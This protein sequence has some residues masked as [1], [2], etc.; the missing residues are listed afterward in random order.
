MK[1]LEGTQTKINLLKG[2]AGESEARNRYTFFAGVAKR[3][4]YEQISA[5]FL[6]T[7][8]NE[9]AH[10]KVFFRYLN[11]ESAEITS[12]VVTG[13]LKTTHECLLE[14]AAGEYNEWHNLYNTWADT[15][16]QEGFPD[17]ADSLRLIATVEMHHENR[18]RKLAGN[19]VDGTV[20]EKPLVIK[21]ICRNCGYIHEGEDAPDVCP[22]CKH[23]QAFFEVL[24]DN[25]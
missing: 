12:E 20:F 14:A 1:S 25:F 19:I 17:I 4:G 9:R 22:V 15:A 24:A 18:Y 5:I 7:A 8:D 2:F 23:P 13:T 16:D 10:A 11:G 6:A 3:E 21:W